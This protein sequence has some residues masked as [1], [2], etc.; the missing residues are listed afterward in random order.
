MK[1]ELSSF[2]LKILLGIAVL[3]IIGGFLFYGQFKWAVLLIVVGVAGVL[4]SLFL[5]YADE[6][7]RETAFFQGQMVQLLKEQQDFYTKKMDY[8]LDRIQT[9]DPVLAHNLNVPPLP[10]QPSDKQIVNFPTVDG[11]TLKEVPK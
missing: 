1:P 6:R 8:L 10:K 4:I 11:V 9:G 5:N 3:S 7:A 2:I